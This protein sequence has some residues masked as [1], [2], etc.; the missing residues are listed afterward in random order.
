[1]ERRRSARAH[2]TTPSYVEPKQSD[3]YH[4]LSK[5][6]RWQTD[7]SSDAD[8]DVDEDDDEEVP[9]TRMRQQADHARKK[10]RIEAI[11]L[12]TV[13][14]AATTTRSRRSSASTS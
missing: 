11:A 6:E 8:E 4:P 2:T 14:A 1:M 9:I 7:W 10:Q 13:A 5:R 3:I 12:A